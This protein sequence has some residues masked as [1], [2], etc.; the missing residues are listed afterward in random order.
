MYLHYKATTPIIYP[1]PFVGDENQRLLMI[2]VRSIYDKYVLTDKEVIR[3][4]LFAKSNS[5]K[6]QVFF[7]LAK[8]LSFI[9]ARIF[10]PYIYYN[11]LKKAIQ[12][13]LC[14]FVDVRTF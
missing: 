13:R 7:S 1:N 10:S 14:Y 3:F 9:P 12:S 6:M 11:I 4:L 5:G 8:F 2:Y